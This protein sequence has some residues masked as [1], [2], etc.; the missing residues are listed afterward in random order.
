MRQ[1]RHLVTNN[2]LMSS[3]LFL[4]SGCS[5]T[6]VFGTGTKFGVDIS[7]RPDQIIEV[8]MGYDRYEVV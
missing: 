7:Q 4:L 5:N 2:I 1:L 6:L 3:L 8:T